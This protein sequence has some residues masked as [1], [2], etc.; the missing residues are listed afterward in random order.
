MVLQ[1]HS[2]PASRGDRVTGA[3][4]DAVVVSIAVFVVWTFFGWFLQLLPDTGEQV[5]FGD[6]MCTGGGC[7]YTWF[8]EHGIGQGVTFWVSL[9]LT[10]AAVAALS[11]AF[12]RSRRSTGMHVAS[13]YPVRAATVGTTDLEPPPRAALAARWGIVLALFA[14]GVVVNGGVLGVLLVFLAW[15][16]SLVGPRQAVYDWLTGVAVVGVAPR[17]VEPADAEGPA[18]DQARPAGRRAD[19]RPADPGDV[20]WPF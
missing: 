6:G 18:E 15:L 19:D 1:V 10:V 4:V 2:R 20:D 8:A 12:G 7:D 14:L 16:P 11:G 5:G 13:T 9:V 17:H 3:F